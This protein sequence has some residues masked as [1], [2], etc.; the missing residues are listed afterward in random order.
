MRRQ[1]IGLRIYRALIPPRPFLVISGTEDSEIPIECSR[2]LHEA[3]REPKTIRWIDTGH[4]TIRDTEFHETVKS[5]LIDW[6]VSEGL[7]G[8][9]CFSQ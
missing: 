2:L 9:E 6:L 5:E 3:A 7:V 8:R 1:G 4:V